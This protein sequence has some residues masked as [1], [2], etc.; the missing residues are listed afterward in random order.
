MRHPTSMPT[1]RLRRHQ[2]RDHQTAEGRQPPLQCPH[3][4]CFAFTAADPS[5]SCIPGCEKSKEM[6][7]V[8]VAAMGFCIG[9]DSPLC[10]H[11]HEFVEE[12]LPISPELRSL[13][14]SP[15]ASAAERQQP[16]RTKGFGHPL[17]R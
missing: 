6:S 4:L 14:S 7:S 8:Q 17:T 1:L 12:K 9:S 10:G 13:R 3:L 5:C 11:L 2:E 15:E 16:L